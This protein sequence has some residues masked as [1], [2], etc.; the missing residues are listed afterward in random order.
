V[1]DGSGAPQTPKQLGFLIRDAVG[2]IACGILASVCFSNE[3]KVGGLWFS[4][5]GLVS[6][7]HIPTHYLAR[8][9]PLKKFFIWLL[10]FVLIVGL[11]IWCSV[12]SYRLLHPVKNVTNSEPFKLAQNPTEIK[13]TLEEEINMNARRAMA[14][15]WQPPQFPEGAQGVLLLVGGTVAEFFDRS[16]LMSQ[17]PMVIGPA[18]R[19]VVFPYLTNNRVF[20]KTQLPSGDG[21]TTVK[22]SDEWPPQIP[23]G[24]DKN[25]NSQ[26]FEIVDEETNPVF[27]IRYDNPTQIEVFG[28]FVS[29]NGGISV[30]FNGIS[31]MSPGYQISSIPRVKAWFKYPSKD[32]LGD[33][34]GK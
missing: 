16:R 20:I 32:H 31:Q 19:D 21:P 17:I 1:T 34:V 18:G 25:F 2:I 6:A 3:Y 7:F 9:N 22:M 13:P 10:F 27:Q 5:V 12:W 26:E 8:T 30:D 14:K 11:G 4:F 24:W 28:I 23:A 33:V 15:N 29:E